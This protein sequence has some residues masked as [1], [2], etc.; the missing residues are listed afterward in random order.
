VTCKHEKS[1]W[2][3]FL[4]WNNKIYWICV[5]PK[6]SERKAFSVRPKNQNLKKEMKMVKKMNS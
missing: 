6:F 3:I 4:S 2:M 5:T 1:T